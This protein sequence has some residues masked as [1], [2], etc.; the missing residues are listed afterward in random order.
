MLLETSLENGLRIFDITFHTHKDTPPINHTRLEIK[1]SVLYN[2]MGGKF[3][4]LLAAILV[5]PLRS[6]SS[7]KGLNHVDTKGL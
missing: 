7:Q 3:E 1:Y 4:G 5:E 6:R 2:E